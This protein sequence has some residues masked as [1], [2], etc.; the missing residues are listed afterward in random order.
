MLGHELSRSKN[1]F[2]AVMTAL[3]LPL[4]NSLALTTSSKI[5]GLSCIAPV[6]DE[7]QQAVQVS[8]AF[9]ADLRPSPHQDSDRYGS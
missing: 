9:D 8:I 1:L 6:L 7:K 5:T 4:L 3:S 2:P